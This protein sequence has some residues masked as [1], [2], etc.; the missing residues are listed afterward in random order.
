MPFERIAEEKIKEAMA[1]G[2][3]SELPGKGKPLNLEEYFSAPEDMRL[4]LS[5]L[6]NAGFVPDEVQL[7]RDIHQL[8]VR[9]KDTSDDKERH[10]ISKEIER[11]KMTLNLL[12][13]RH[14]NRNRR[15]RTR[16]L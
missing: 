13:E 16:F 4:G 12:L 8:I 2:E 5:I 10:R 15:K 7:F 6:K 1:R 14:Q 9:R 3:F 11:K